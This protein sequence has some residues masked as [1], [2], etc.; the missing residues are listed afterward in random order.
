MQIDINSPEGKNLYNYRA[1]FKPHIAVHW[2]DPG[3][4]EDARKLVDRIISDG[5][6]QSTS[7]LPVYLAKEE[8]YEQYSN[9]IQINKDYYEKLRMSKRPIFPY[10][11]QYEEWNYV[12]Y[13]QKAGK[14]L[15]FMTGGL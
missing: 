15:V 5:F 4:P 12:V 6:K 11:T 13:D 3:L 10:L 9:E 8:F 2:E 1:K 14:G 7:N